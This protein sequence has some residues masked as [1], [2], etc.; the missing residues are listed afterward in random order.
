MGNIVNIANVRLPSAPADAITVEACGTCGS[1]HWHLVSDG[2]ML[3]AKCR[4]QN[5]TA[6]WRHGQPVDGE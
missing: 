4:C 2:S 5:E 1:I 3:C 6:R